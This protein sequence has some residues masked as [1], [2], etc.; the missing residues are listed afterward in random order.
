MV[1]MYVLKK[2]LVCEG[3]KQHRD[4]DPHEFH[5]VVQGS[6][7][8]EKQQKVLIIR[9]DHICKLEKYKT[10]KQKYKTQPKHIK[11]NQYK[12]KP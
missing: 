10:N 1:E 3:K 7:P 6:F 5:A 4:T 8:S 11:K 2:L 9:Q 12:P